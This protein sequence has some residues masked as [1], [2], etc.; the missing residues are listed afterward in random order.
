[1]SNLFD[2]A[3]NF[4]SD[5]F[6]KDLDAVIERAKINNVN[7]FLIVSASLNDFEKTY[8]IYKSNLKD[9][10]FSIGTHPHHADE[11]NEEQIKMIIEYIDPHVW[12]I[13]MKRFEKDFNWVKQLLK[14]AN[15]S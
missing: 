11:I 12:Q 1:M 14:K 8:N 4:S 7:K 3:C 10:F 2:I 15:L 6:D 13:K 5:R 9:A